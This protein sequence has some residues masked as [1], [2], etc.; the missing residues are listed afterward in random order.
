MLPTR[1]FEMTAPP[2]DSLPLEIA[3]CAGRMQ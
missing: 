2:I 1:V 3:A